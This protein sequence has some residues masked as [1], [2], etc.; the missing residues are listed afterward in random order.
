MGK[1]F[2]HIRFVHDETPLS[3]AA[4]QAAFHTGGRL[5]P[6]LNDL[7]VPAIDLAR[8]LPEAVQRLCDRAGQDPE[9]ILEN[10]ITALGPRRYQLRGCTFS[11]EFT[12]GKDT[13]ICPLCL[14]E[15]QHDQKRP[16]V[17]VRHRVM[18]RLAPVRTCGVHGVLLRDIRTGA[19]HDQFHEL[20]GLGDAIAAQ[21]EV[22]ADE[23]RQPSKLQTYVENRLA[24][25]AGPEWM[26]GQDIDQAVRATEMLGGLIA[27]G[28]AQSAAAMTS[29]TWDEAGRAAWDVVS[30]GEQALLQFFEGALTASARQE[31]QARPR[32]TFGMLYSW[33]SASRGTKDPGPIRDVLRN[34]IVE[35][36]PLVPG[37]MLLG[38]PVS[39]PRLSNIA[40]VAKAELMHP[41]TLR[42]VLVA[43]GVLTAEGELGGSSVVVDYWRAR[44]LIDAAKHAMGFAAVAEILNTSRP[45]VQALLE[46]GVLKRVQETPVSG[47]K[48]GKAIDGRSVHKVKLFIDRGLLAVPD[49]PENFEHLAKAAERSRTKLKVILELMFKGHLTETFRLKE[50]SGFA[51]VLV[52]PSEVVSLMESPPSDLSEDARFMI[53]GH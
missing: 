24:G 53:P 19:W 51:S 26:D 9:P 15:D 39:K 29:R 46:I 1:L 45:V 41:K 32:K 3:W 27:F 34:A 22:T 11:A 30:G 6:F 37:Q 13:R 23:L 10:T 36:T 31:G 8:G 25:H 52:R 50:A 47:S 44:D 5:V 20:Q 4:R 35:N 12:T 16:D 42:N 21:H 2:P 43:S 28:P 33:L 49:A 7:Q 38:K 48:V 17:A 18:W 40:S 14:S